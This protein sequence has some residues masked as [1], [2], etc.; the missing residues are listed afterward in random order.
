MILAIA[1]LVASIIL[2][3][4][5]SQRLYPIIAVAASGIEVLLALHILNLSL[6]LPGGIGLGLILGAALAIAGVLMYMKVGGKTA[7]A[8][9]TIVGFVGIIQ[10]LTALHILR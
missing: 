10:V 3:M 7:V 4:Q 8:C 9:A 1:A 2:L 5:L 6:S